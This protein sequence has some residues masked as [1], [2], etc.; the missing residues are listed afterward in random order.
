[1]TALQE[2]SD[3]LQRITFSL[4]V[5]CSTANYNFLLN[6]SGGNTVGRYNILAIFY[7]CLQAA[8]LSLPVDSRV[9]D[10]IK[11]QVTDGVR[12]IAEIRRHTEIYVKRT[13]FCD[14]AVPSRFNR[15][16]FPL[17]RDYNNIVYKTRTALMQS[18]FDQENLKI[19]ITNWK[20]DQPTDNFFLRPF[21]ENCGTTS[22]DDNGDLQVVGTGGTGLLIVHQT[23]WQR[24]LLE[25]YGNMCLLDATYKTTRYAL[26]LFF[27][28][29]RTNVDYVVVATFVIQHED[30]SSISEAL[31]VV[32]SWNS[33][34]T[35][36]SFMVD[37]CEAEM[38]AIEAVF[39]G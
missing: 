21:V 19:K 37:C 14:K 3:L 20:A 27:L 13:I 7:V 30:S 34:W 5:D 12:N 36:A 15:R 4:K 17:R 9:Q 23:S 24:K 39:T 2:M 32:K 6:I 31:S 33:S 11:Q 26:P 25:K 28:C 29:V 22:I 35:P 38:K 1:V 10:F 18:C 8:G 16:F